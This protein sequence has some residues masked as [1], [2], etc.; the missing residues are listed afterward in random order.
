MSP[1]TISHFSA[2]CKKFEVHLA[3]VSPS[4]IDKR[5]KDIKCHQMFYIGQFLV[6][7]GQSISNISKNI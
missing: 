7:G 5:K 4:I 3:F 1:T 2:S 6:N